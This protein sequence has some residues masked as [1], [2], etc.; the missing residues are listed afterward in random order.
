MPLHIHPDIEQLVPYSPGKPLDEL[1]RELG[2]HHA[3]KLASNENPLGPSPRALAV[4]HD[5]AKTLNRYP[6]GGAHHLIRA[7][8]DRWKVGANQIVVGNGS[9]EI[10]GLLVKA[11][12]SPGDEAIMADHTFM[13]YKLAV[14]AGHGVSI[15]IP[16]VNW[17]HDLASMVKAITPRTKLVFVCNPNNPTG[18]MVTKDEVAHLMAQLPDHVIVVFDE[19]YHEYVRDPEYPDTLQYVLSQRNAIVLRTFSKIYGLAGLRIGYGL[20]TPTIV[21]YLNR[22]RPPFNTNSLAQHAAVAAMAD[23]EH[24]SRSR[25]LNASE[26]QV[27]ENGLRKL[28]IEPIPSQAN[29]LYFDTH[30][31]GRQI[32]DQLLR[33]GVIVRHIRGSMLRVTIGRPEENR[34]F[35]DALR[36]VLHHHPAKNPA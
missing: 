10:I 14:T 4:L 1:E 28:G 16:L 13:M 11:F 20:T 25:T 15:E 30:Q 18:T 26:M 3:V 6:D 8:A 36:T 32:F 2:I 29:F 33:E 9:D 24:L 31:D 22:V 27:V 21:N 5:V 35:L 34:R 23:D 19:A 17:R 12:L 7:L